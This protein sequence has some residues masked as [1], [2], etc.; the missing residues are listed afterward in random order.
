MHSLV[1][2][3]YRNEESLPE[4][5]IQLERIHEALG[6]NLEVVF[7]VDASPD[8]SLAR[9]LAFRKVSPFRM[10]VISLSRNFG[11]FA[12]IRAG[13]SVAEGPYFCTIAADLQEPP[14]LSLDIF[15]KLRANDADIVVAARDSRQD[16]L[17][18]ALP[19]KIFWALYRKL[20]QRE[21]PVGGV[22]LFGCNLKVRNVLLKLEESNSSLI[23]QIFWI[24]YRRTEVRYSRLQRRH[25]KSAWSLSKKIKY[26]LDSIFAFTDLPIRLLLG[27]GTGGILVSIALFLIVGFSRLMGWIHVPGYAAIMLSYM[28]FSAINLFGLG[29]IGGYVWRGYENSKGRPN[30][31]IM[32][33]HAIEESN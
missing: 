24:G 27:L 5:F 19:S 17:L 10:R 25:G 12:A 6:R 32:D 31:L 7:A 20:V 21:V 2:P 22:D 4:L 16:P 18:S 30:F 8:A 9:I 15:A 26:M 33:D 29:I 1:I 3:V 14:E 28:F 13:L 11:S 23:G